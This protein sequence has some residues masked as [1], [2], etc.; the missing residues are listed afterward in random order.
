MHDARVDIVDGELGV[1]A[2]VD[3]E[4]NRFIIK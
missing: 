2:A 4:G 3:L 1:G